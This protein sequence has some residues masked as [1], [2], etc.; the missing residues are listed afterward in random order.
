MPLPA[1][2][3]EA[4]TGGE[5]GESTLAWLTAL[6]KIGRSVNHARPL[7]DVLAMIAETV[8]QLMDYHFC[9]VL[10]SRPD[11]PRL[12]F[13]GTAGLSAEYAAR[14]NAERPISLV[15]GDPL[16]DGPSTQA[17]RTMETIVIDDIEHDACLQP[18]TAL[19]SA[20]GLTSMVC[21]P[22]VAS[23]SAL[24]VLTCYANQP[25]R[26]GFESIA[27]IECL[28]EQAAIAIE[29]A[30]QRMREKQT[31]SHLQYLNAALEG[32]RDLIAR[33]EALHRELMQLAVSGS[34]LE[35]V[36]DAVAR[37]LG[38]PVVLEAAGSPIIPGDARVPEGPIDP[39]HEAAVMENG[40]PVGRLVVDIPAANASEAAWR[41]RALES[42][43]LVVSLQLQRESAAL[44]ER[45]RHSGE[46]LGRLLSPDG[47]VDEWAFQR[48]ASQLGHELTV[49]HTVMVASAEPM[50][51][52]TSVPDPL[53]VQR[54]ISA[55][56]RAVTD[57]VRPRPLVGPLHDFI[58]VLLPTNAKGEREAIG[59][60]AEELRQRSC[61]VLPG[62]KVSVAI[63]PSCSE[64][65]A[66]ADVARV[67]ATALALTA[68]GKREGSV[69]ALGNL[70][71]YNFLLQA[72]RPAELAQF[73]SELLDPI[74]EPNHGVLLPTLRAFLDNRM[75]TATTAA[76]LVVHVN[77]VTYRLRQVETILGIDLRDPE[78]L[79]RMKF[80]LMIDALASA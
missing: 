59:R 6:A 74:R 61:A 62:F 33:T 1:A 64:L 43:A 55:I 76:A 60:M 38:G 67:A 9:G 79:L 39:G 68:G 49:P 16:A 35:D 23:G 3:P 69:V 72:R 50:D 58:A 54:R 57:G 65:G 24:G 80:A 34:D 44:E 11:P 31:I 10:L 20:E 51:E 53:T 25:D 36:V 12:V 18:W 7:G 8:C 15:P 48:R 14:V 5:A 42:G 73:A 75:S 78:V 4:S 40:E 22:L 46:L 19:A 29:A 21:V 37:T 52:A 17:F 27:R 28:A 70:G 41:R 77:T 66:F 26:F 13:E 56:A 63:G 45:L 30:D 2:T 71:L 32:Q 47:P